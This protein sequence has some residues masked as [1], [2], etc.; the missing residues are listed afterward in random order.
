VTAFIISLLVV[1]LL[2][3]GGI[4]I[5]FFR[6]KGKYMRLAD[7]LCDPG[8]GRIKFYLR[9]MTL[10]G[11]VKGL[12]VRYSVFGDER[13]GFPVSSYLLLEYPVR[14]NLRFYAE[15]DLRGLPPELQAPLRAIQE[16]TDFRGLVLTP[17]DSPFLGCF[18]SRPLGLGYRPGIL[19]WKWETT[20]F[21]ASLIE[22]DLDVLLDAAKKG[23]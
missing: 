2:V 7:S 11:K 15:S 1:L 3:F 16:T 19:L 5:Q 6:Y 9:T 22:R 4:F 14:T 10:K 12:P 17:Q 8:T 18:L 21:D 20:P 23:V 13:S